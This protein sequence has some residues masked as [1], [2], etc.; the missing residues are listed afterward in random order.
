MLMQRREGEQDADAEVVE[1]V[2]QSIG[3][4]AECAGA[5]LRARCRMLSRGAEGMVLKGRSG[6]GRAEEAR[7]EDEESRGGKNKGRES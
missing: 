3:D 1:W 4:C 7:A 6:K 5:E 2:E